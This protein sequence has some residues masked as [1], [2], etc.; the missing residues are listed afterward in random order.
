MMRAQKIAA[1]TLLAVAASVALA[2]QAPRIA[3]Q[4]SKMEATRMGILLAER[5]NLLRAKEKATEKETLARI[6]S[7]IKSLDREIART[8]KQPQT[9]IVTTSTQIPAARKVA[10]ARSEPTVQTVVMDTQP[11][12]EK[13][14]ESWDVFKNFG[15]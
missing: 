9:N 2:Q 8:N 13:S 4:T 11:S 3:A 6:E 14:Y 12:Q 15:N 1:A 5:N 7:D 10:V